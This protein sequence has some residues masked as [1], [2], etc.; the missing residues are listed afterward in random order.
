[1]VQVNDIM[2]DSVPCCDNVT[3]RD[4]V[5]DRLTDFRISPL[6]EGQ[7]SLARKDMW[8]SRRAHPARSLFSYDHAT[9]TLLQNRHYA[10]AVIRT[11]CGWTADTGRCGT[12]ALRAAH[13]L[14]QLAPLGLSFH[15]DMRDRRVG[16]SRLSPKGKII[17]VFQHNRPAG[18]HGAILWPLLPHYHHLGSP[19]FFGGATR[20]STAFRAKKPQIFWRGSLNGRDAQD[21]HPTTLARA[22]EAGT[23]DH[24][25][26]LE[27]VMT[28]PR[29]ALV[30]RFQDHPLCDF[31]LVDTASRFWSRLYGLRRS[32][33]VARE[34]AC[35]FRYQLVVEGNDRGSN[36]PWL[37]ET[38]CLILRQDMEWQSFYDDMFRPWEHF[39][40]IAR[41]F[42]DLED[43][44]EWCERHLDRC[45]QIIETAQNTARMIAARG[46]IED[47]NDRVIARYRAITKGLEM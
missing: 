43:K 31:A 27:H 3:D 4:T 35:L 47:S 37:C 32:G 11:E 30:R 14:D 15:A 2:R 46:F 13:L 9:G 25:A 29:F 1:M 19:T 36:F 42:S 40:P 44:Y 22:V 6:L 10:E 28:V 7:I 16:A 5:L 20:D 23:L 21:R 34:D 38:N 45:A 12:S 24:D 33:R 17:P 18:A 26:C 8:A 41:D 39:I